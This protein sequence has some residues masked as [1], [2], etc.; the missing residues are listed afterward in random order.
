MTY[1]PTTTGCSVTMKRS[2]GTLLLSAG[3]FEPAG[4][5]SSTVVVIGS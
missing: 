4:A 1:G 2:K 3:P 5:V